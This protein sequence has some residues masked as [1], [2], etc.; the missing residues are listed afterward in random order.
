MDNFNSYDL[1]KSL[2]K[3]LDRLEM[4]KPT[5]VQ[6]QAIPEALNGKDLIVSA[7]TGTGKTLA[8][9][10]PVVAKLIENKNLG[11][12]VITPTRELAAQISQV[13]KSLLF[14]NQEIKS[15]LLIGGA[16]MGPQFASLRQNPQLIVGTP[17]R[18]TDHLKAGRL[19]LDNTKFVVLDEMDRMLDMGFSIQIDEILTFMQYK[20]Q[21]MMLSATISAAI[22]KLSAKYL[23]EPVSVS[24]AANQIVNNSVKQEFLHLNRDDKYPE[25][26]K[27]LSERKGTIIIFVKTRRNADEIADM[28]YNDNFKARAI[29]GDLRQNQ[30]DKIIRL[31]RRGE[32]DIIVA[33][34]VASRGLDVPHI[35][36]VINYNLPTNPEDYVHRVGRTGRAGEEG[37]AVTFVSSNERKE[38]YALE[39]FLD[40]E[41][42]RNFINDNKSSRGRAARRGRSD[43]KFADKSRSSKRGSSAK[44]KARNNKDDARKT[45]PKSRRDVRSENTQKRLGDNKRSEVR[46]SS[47]E[48]RKDFRS[49]NTQKRSGD[50]KRSEVRRSSVESRRDVRGENTQKRSGD[51]KRSGDFALRN[52]SKAKTSNQKFNGRFVSDDKSK[53]APKKK[54]SADISDRTDRKPRRVATKRQTQ[55]PKDPRKLK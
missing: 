26:V 6:I 13:L 28:L 18:I 14:F 51:N 42:K 39:A 33:T 11:V 50:N 10:I 55:H 47:V 9:S 27:Q 8:F 36:H 22:R 3:A 20:R 46:R 21:T 16:P 37:E 35:R 52:R 24:I 34:D 53:E 43:N 23:S 30:R 45:S 1:P 48:S 15:A 32:F 29:H 49:E 40:P 17:G 19:V 4:N 25:L 54:F 12:I 31:L 44:L 2:H 7:P 41:K 5:D 38:W